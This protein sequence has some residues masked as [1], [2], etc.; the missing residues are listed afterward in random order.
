M[1]RK[2]FLTKP[3]VFLKSPNLIQEVIGLYLKGKSAVSI[4]NKYKC[5]FRTLIKVLKENNIKLRT[6]QQPLK[7]YNFNES[8]FEKID[9]HEKAQI[10]GMLAADGCLYNGRYTQIAL[11]IDDLDY[12]KWIKERIE[13]NGK[14]YFPNRKKNNKKE[15][16]ICSLCI[17]SKKLYEDLEKLG[18][19][20]QKS[21]TLPFPLEKQ[22][23]K[24]FLNSFVLGYFEGDGG[25]YINKNC[26]CHIHFA[27]SD[28]FCQELRDVIKKELNISFG[29]QKHGKIS[30]LYLQGNVQGFKFLN[31]IYK[32]A[33]FQMGQ[34]YKKFLMLKNK[35]TEK[36]QL[37]IVHASGENNPSCKLTP[38][39]VLEIR[40]KNKLGISERKLA[41]LYNVTRSTIHNIKHFKTWVHLTSEKI[42]LYQS[43]NINKLCKN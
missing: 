29:I 41:K 14:I 27:G 8:Y 24:Q 10:L 36:H 38:V 34:K 40:N 21:L 20:K 19:Y 43:K 35:F 33:K 25:I 28:N 5:S 7:K 22:V 4:S 11:Q 9:N 2:Q 17:C 18:L 12:I 26:S 6:V 15:K 42:Y 23:P 3:S 37:G 32:N 30:Q 13:Y 31:W 1:T 39:Q 16:Q